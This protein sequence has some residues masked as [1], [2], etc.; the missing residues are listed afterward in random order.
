MTPIKTHP[1]EG[2]TWRGFL[3]YLDT[4]PPVRRD[5]AADDRAFAALARAVEGRLGCAITVEDSRSCQDEAVYGRMLLPSEILTEEYMAWLSA[6][7]IGNLA[8]VWDWDGVVQPKKLALIGETVEEHGL[9]Y[10]PSAV[11]YTTFTGRSHD[12]RRDS[13]HERFFGYL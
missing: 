7:R 2:F 1:W 8:T 9:F 3:E 13:W 6:S 4:S 12:A 5:P 11:L 10:V